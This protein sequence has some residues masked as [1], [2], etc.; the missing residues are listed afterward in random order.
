MQVFYKNLNSLRFIAAA[1]VI[2]HHVEQNKWFNGLPHHF[3]NPIIVL[4]GKLGVNIF[5]VLSGFLITSLL[6]IEK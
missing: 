5:F 3:E 6:V 2:V 1:M 4:F